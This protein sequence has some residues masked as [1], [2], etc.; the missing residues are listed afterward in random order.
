MKF[1]QST[2][3]CSTPFQKC[4]KFSER[5]ILLPILVHI[6]LL[7]NKIFLKKKFLK[8]AGLPLNSFRRIFETDP[9]LFQKEFQGVKNAKNHQ[10]L[11]HF[12]AVEKL[13]AHRNW[14]LKLEFFK[15]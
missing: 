5:S 6:F 14:K 11:S 10:F 3:N 13:K 7:E 8:N 9:T 1:P 12:I 2:L 15:F 4:S